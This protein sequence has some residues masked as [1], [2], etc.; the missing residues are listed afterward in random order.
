MKDITFT[1]QNKEFLLPADSLNERSFTVQSSLRPYRVAVLEDMRSIL[2]VLPEKNGKNLLLID[3]KVYAHYAPLFSAVSRVDM[4]LAEATE[5]LK[6]VDGVLQVIDFLAERDFTRGDTLLVVGGGVIQDVG[7]FVGAVYKRGI[8]WVFFPTT[9]LAM[10]DSCIGAKA[11]INY[12]GAKNQLGLFSAP[13]QVVINLSFLQTLA[14]RDLKSGLGEIVKLHIIGGKEMLKAY[15]SLMGKSEAKSLSA[16]GELIVGALAVKRV[17]IEADEFEHN[18][19]RGLN[20]GHTL[21][22]AIEALS[23]YAIAH[24]EAVVLGMLVANALAQK[25]NVLSRQENEELRDLL[26]LFLDEKLKQRLKTLSLD[27]MSSVLRKDKKALGEQLTFVMLRS[28]GDTVFLP[29]RLDEALLDEVRAT[30]N[31]IFV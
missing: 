27:D 6:T 2:A 9:L 30:I 13:S 18:Y 25:R 19:R 4:L 24:G 1:I 21:G 17:V 29:L 26:L 8:D 11:A 20:Y 5:E 31:D 14:E 28:I 15:A 10:A 16:L 12:R 23:N 7:A 22:H 3:K